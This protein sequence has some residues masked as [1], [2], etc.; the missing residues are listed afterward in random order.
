MDRM[1]SHT[2]GILILLL[3]SI[4]FIL[5][6]RQMQ[7]TLKLIAPDNRKIKPAYVWFTLIPIPILSNIWWFFL[8]ALISR[9]IEL[10]YKTRNIPVKYKPTYL[11]GIITGILSFLGT[12]SSIRFPHST[13]LKNI[14]ILF[15]VFFIIYWM[16]VLQCKRKL[17]E[18][19]PVENI[20]P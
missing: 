7:N 18:S 2:V 15:G 6:L 16:Q 8:V 4:P 1:I 10:E 13:E 3:L 9:S 11:A 12:I 19:P 20:L 14:A 5:F 17:M